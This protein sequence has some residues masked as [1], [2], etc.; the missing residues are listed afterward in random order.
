MEILSLPA[1]L[2]DPAVIAASLRLRGG[3]GLVTRLAEAVAGAAAPTAA[4]RRLQ[5]TG[6]EEGGVVLE[7]I[8]L[9]SR[10][11][12]RMALEPG[13]AGGALY[14][15]LI[16]TGAALEELAAA[17]EG[18]LAQFLLDEMGNRVLAQARDRFEAHLRLRFDLAQVGSLA[19]GAL[20]DWP[21][22]EQRPLF[23]LLG[24]LPAAMGVRLTAS[25]LMLPRK[26]ISGIYFPAGEAFVSCTLCPRELCAGRRAPFEA[27]RARQLGAA[28][29][30][31]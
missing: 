3:M 21:L 11:L 19:P 30:G 6:L 24:H 17:T 4:F 26:T 10:V 29:K 27:A 12:R 2:L 31:C 18:L 28:G 16:T 5:V 8:L 14:A 22:E 1:P 15:A 9:R 13:V 20:P 23:A 25:G 7:G